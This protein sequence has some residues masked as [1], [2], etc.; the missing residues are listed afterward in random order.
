MVFSACVDRFDRSQSKKTMNDVAWTGGG[1]GGGAGGGAGSL[2]AASN[3]AV[4]KAI[5]SFL[6]MKSFPRRDR[7]PAEHNGILLP[8]FQLSPVL[9]F[10]S[11]LQQCRV[12]PLDEKIIPFVS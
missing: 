2:H 4:A 11:L 3:D 8:R 6:I 7:W 5:S 1:G 12:A 9:L 10:G